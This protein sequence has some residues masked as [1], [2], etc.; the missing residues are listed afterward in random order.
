MTAGIFVRRHWRGLLILAAFW[1]TA[2]VLQSTPF[3]V[4]LWTCAAGL[5]VYVW[6][7]RRRKALFAET[8]ER[9]PFWALMRD[10]WVERG[11]RA[12][13]LRQ[14]DLACQQSGLHVG[15]NKR[16]PTLWRLTSTVDGDFTAVIAPGRIGLVV[17][18]VLKAADRIRQIVGCYEVTV[19][20]LP[21]PA[22]AKVCFYWKDSIS[23]VL[24]LTEMPASKAGQI[25]YGIRQ[26]GLA[27]VVLLYLSILI[28]G[29]TRHG[30]SN[31]VKALIAD[32][33]NKKVPFRLYISDPKGGMELSDFGLRVGEQLGPMQVVEYVTDEAG[34]VAMVKRAHAAMLERQR[35]QKTKDHVP[36]VESPLTIVL[37][38]ELLMLSDMLKK[39]TAGELGKILFTGA[40]SGFVVWANTQ[41][42]HEA[43]LGRCRDLFPQRLCFAT[44][45]S[46]TTD[47]ILG[48]GAESLGARCSQIH[49]AG[50]GYSSAEHSQQMERF[51]GALVTPE[52]AECLSRGVVP[53]G[54]GRRVVTRHQRYAMYHLWSWEDES[55]ARRLLYVGITDGPKRRLAQHAKDKPWWPEVDP[56]ATGIVWLQDE[57]SARREEALAIEGEMPLYNEVHNGGNPTRRRRLRSVA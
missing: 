17:T 27:A 49:V 46:Q 9:R 52:D 15:K 5:W 54:M 56:S 40:A 55:G 14:W 18:D 47:T 4:F 50:V 20:P 26:N 21:D 32:L 13:L 30:K 12:T 7:W 51:R 19:T 34:T 11:R 57:A 23:R 25:A 3:A 44:R 1:W 8:G 53:D 43:E 36:S 29:L 39:G 37:L 22:K 42:G 6:A 33:I 10:W 35:T 28:G 45:T 2:S 16:T 38:D 24:P 48:T 41:V 31:A